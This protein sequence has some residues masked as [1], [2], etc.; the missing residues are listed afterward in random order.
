VSARRSIVPVSPSLLARACAAVEGALHDTHYLDG[1]LDALRSAVA[2]PGDDGHALACV[3]DDALDGVIVFGLFGGASGAGRLHF[4][5]VEQ[6]ARRTGTARA[7][8]DAALHALTASG[9]RFALVELPDDPRELPGARDLFRALGFSEESRVDDFYRD[10]VG[11]SFLRR[12][13]GP[14]S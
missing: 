13:L 14:L 6:A 8:V 2:A 5:L 1:A 3:S 10:G 9:A 11:L 7:L 12:E 4:V